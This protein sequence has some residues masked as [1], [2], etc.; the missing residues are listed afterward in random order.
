MPKTLPNPPTYRKVNPADSPILILGA[1]SDTLPLTEVDDNVETKLA[2]R[3]SQVSGVAQVQIGGQQN[4]RS[5]SSSIRPSSSPRGCPWRMC[6]PPSVT[7]V[8]SPK[9]TI[10]GQTRSFT[11]YTNDQLSAAKDWNDTIVAYHNGGAVRVSDIG[12]AVQRGPRIPSG[13]AWADGKPG[14][15]LVILSSSP[16]PTSSTTVDN[17]MA[18]LPQLDG[19]DSHRGQGLGPQRPDSDDPGLRA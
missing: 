9:G 12:S 4:P 2:Q 5:A 3:I 1:T 19:R 15:F 16:G 11:I 14:I 8:D 10:N 18:E 7:T 6:A 13:A 17:V